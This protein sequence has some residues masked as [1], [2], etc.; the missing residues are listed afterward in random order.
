MM[1]AILFFG[2]FSVFCLGGCSISRPCSEGG[3]TSWTPKIIGDKRCEQKKSSAG[4]PVN[5]GKFLQKYQSTGKIALEGQFENGKK[6]GIWCYYGPDGKLLAV[7]YFDQGVEKTPPIE[8]QKKVDLI[9]Q[10]KAGANGLSP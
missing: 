10:Q 7:K 5:D 3:D 6:Q 2:F 4:K 9:I 1:R 8:F